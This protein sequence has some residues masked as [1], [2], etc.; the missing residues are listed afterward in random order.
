MNLETGLC[1]QNE[2]CLSDSPETVWPSNCLK[3]RTIFFPTFD[4]NSFGQNTG[5]SE[6]SRGLATPC[7]KVLS[8]GISA[9][10]GNSIM[11]LNTLRH[12]PADCF[13]SDVTVW[14]RH[15]FTRLRKRREIN[16]LWLSKLHQ[17]GCCNC[18]GFPWGNDCSG[19]SDPNSR[20]TRRCLP[21]VSKVCKCIPRI[22]CAI[23]EWWLLY[24]FLHWSAKTVLSEDFPSRSGK[25]CVSLRKHKY[26]MR[27]EVLQQGK[28]LLCVFPSGWSLQVFQVH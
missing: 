14:P 27:L 6:A 17:V 13:L 15:V 28:L 16:W 3:I 19:T 21:A 22:Q 25:Q 24:L 20:C 5:I 11:A 10:L 9:N 26:L 2:R 8:F 1:W 7:V 23:H 12:S 18:T 4:S